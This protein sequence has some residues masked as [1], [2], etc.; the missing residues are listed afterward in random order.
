MELVQEADWEQAES[1]FPCDLKAIAS[2]I[3]LPTAAAV[4]RERMCRSKEHM[5]THALIPLTSDERDVI[6]RSIK[7]RG[8]HQAYFRRLVKDLSAEGLVITY[9]DFGYARERVTTARGGWL[10]RYRAVVTATERRLREVGELRDLF[11]LS[12]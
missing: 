3:G 11:T 8:G 9:S 4:I 6:S 10:A 12:G 2:H 5:P 7:G 1:V